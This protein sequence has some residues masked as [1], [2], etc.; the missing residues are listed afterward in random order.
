MNNPNLKIVYINPNPSPKSRT[1]EESLL[2]E[3]ASNHMSLVQ[4]NLNILLKE[5]A[6]AG[7]M[8]NDHVVSRINAIKQSLYIV[9]DYLK[10]CA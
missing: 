5:M 6:K 3:T 9:Q 2:H 1:K 10:E 7:L 4:T 8:E